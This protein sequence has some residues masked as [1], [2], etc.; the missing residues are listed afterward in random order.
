MGCEVLHTN[1]WT[2]AFDLEF[3]PHKLRDLE[4]PEIVQIYQLSECK[5]TFFEFLSAGPVGNK[6]NAINMIAKSPNLRHDTFSLHQPT[7]QP[8]QLQSPQVRL[9]T[10]KH[11][12]QSTA[13][14]R[15]CTEVIFFAW[16]IQRSWKNPLD[17]FSA[18]DCGL[19]AGSLP[20]AS[21][22]STVEKTSFSKTP[23]FR[24]ASD[25]G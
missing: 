14:S 24:Q 19:G 20:P 13:S 10:V 1:E 9:H 11:R 6:E 8:H 17:P 2:S 16:P 4:P 18:A 5:F 25:G 21:K 23:S 22:R 3:Q 7:K 15:L 12:S